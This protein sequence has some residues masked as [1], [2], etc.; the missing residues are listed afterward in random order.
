[1][2]SKEGQSLWNI[3]PR[4]SWEV[5]IG[6]RHEK[7]TSLFRQKKRNWEK[8]P[9]LVLNEFVRNLCLIAQII[10]RKKWRYIPD[11]LKRDL[12]WMEGSDCTPEN[13]RSERSWMGVNRW[14][15][16][17]CD[18]GLSLVALTC[19]YFQVS[20]PTRCSGPVRGTSCWGRPGGA[21]GA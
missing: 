12:G 8:R 4:E 13:S 9:H 6:W 14:E 1:M 10:D 11:S 15:L 18:A 3:V 2:S 21:V 17:L 20:G 19:G 16:R 5:V 7:S